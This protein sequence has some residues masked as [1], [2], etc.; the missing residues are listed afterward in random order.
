MA[1]SNLPLELLEA[2]ALA[3]DR[4]AV[5]QKLVP[6]SASAALITALAEQ[7]GFDLPEWLAHHVT[8]FLQENPHSEL[9][10]AYKLRKQLAGFGKDG[11]SSEVRSSRGDPES[12]PPSPLLTS[13]RFHL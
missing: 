3:D 7:K 5:L 6:G 8:A 4:D 10:R 1:S 13:R 2:F 11:A 12:T 9:A